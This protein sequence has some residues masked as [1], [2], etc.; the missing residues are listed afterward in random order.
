[1][2]TIFLIEINGYFPDF[3]ANGKTEDGRPKTEDSCQSLPKFQGQ[4]HLFSRKQ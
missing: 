4:S 2:K 3:G 1:M